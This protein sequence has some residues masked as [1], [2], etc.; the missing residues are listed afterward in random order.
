MKSRIFLVSSLV[1]ALGLMV[2]G[3]MLSKQPVSQETAP[4]NPV[5]IQA[6]V[7]P[8]N[9]TP[10]EATPAPTSDPLPVEPTSTSFESTTPAHA[11]TDSA[12]EIA[13]Q[14]AK[15]KKPKEPLHDPA[16]R[17][18]LRFVGADPLAEA[19]WLEAIHD[20][21][22]PAQEREDL[23]EDLNE[24]GLSDHKR[25][26]LED[27]PLIMNRIA[28]IEEIVPTSDEFMLV[29]LEEAYKDLLNLAN[30][31]QGEGTPVR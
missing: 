27:F 17:I 20:S 13:P 10:S 18:A 14:S 11:G 31:A 12:V 8:D 24:D 26:G 19:Y 21:S 6:V 28:L 1:I 9:S 30:I 5:R 16:A 25:P 22:L 15:T 3:W 7:S 4:E 23:I 2:A 29:H